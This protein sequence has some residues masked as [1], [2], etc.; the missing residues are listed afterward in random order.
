[1]EDF[2]FELRTRRLAERHKVIIFLAPETCGA[3]L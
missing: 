2:H 1:M 3:A